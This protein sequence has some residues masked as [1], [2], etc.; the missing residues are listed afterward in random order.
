MLKRFNYPTKFLI[1]VT[2]WLVGWYIWHKEL[3]WG[4]VFIAVF[5][6]GLVLLGEYSL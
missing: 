5:T 1:M 4:D 6:C 2:V 3:E